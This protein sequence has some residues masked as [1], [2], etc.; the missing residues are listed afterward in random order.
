MTFPYGS[1]TA[2]TYHSL[3]SGLVKQDYR[4]YM[5]GITQNK[6]LYCDYSTKD[7]FKC[8]RD[9]HLGCTNHFYP[10]GK[11]TFDIC[12]SVNWMSSRAVTEAKTTRKPAILLSGGLTW[13]RKLH[14]TSYD[15]IY[16]LIQNADRRLKERKSLADRGL[17]MR[18]RV[19]L[20]H[21]R[22]DLV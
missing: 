1:K 14:V 16:V 17:H 20:K 9:R 22:K 15:K 6:A 4:T 5:K 7:H 13:I 12:L 18:V 19:I 2:E 3:Y 10:N 8:R 11:E 21:I